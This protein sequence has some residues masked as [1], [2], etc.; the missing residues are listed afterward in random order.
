MGLFHFSQTW[1]G[2]PI[3]EFERKQLDALRDELNAKF[4]QRHATP[5]QTASRSRNYSKQ[6]T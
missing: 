4:E 2:V 3:T 1:R 5:I 6:G